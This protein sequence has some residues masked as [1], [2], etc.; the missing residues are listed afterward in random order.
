M[1]VCRDSEEILV[2]MKIVPHKLDTHITV[3][4]EGFLS[5]DQPYCEK[6][7][8]EKHQSSNLLIPSKSAYLLKTTQL[9]LLHLSLSLPVSYPSAT[10]PKLSLSG[11]YAKFEKELE[12]QLQERWM[13]EQLVLF[14]WFSFLQSELLPVLTKSDILSLGNVAFQEFREEQLRA[15]EFQLET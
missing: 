10:S 3:V 2:N 14:D 6:F 4:L 12:L 13:P 7:S 1:Q 5:K 11:F 8:N 15:V 9:P